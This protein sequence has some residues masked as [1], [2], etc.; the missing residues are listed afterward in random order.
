MLD[1][2]Q[3]GWLATCCGVPC[4]LW[5]LLEIQLVQGEVLQAPPWSLL[6]VV[7]AT[8]TV[9]GGASLWGVRTMRRMIPAPKIA[10]SENDRSPG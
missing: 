6:G 5:Y 4:T 1:A 2:A 8:L 10:D 9:C 7:S 3:L